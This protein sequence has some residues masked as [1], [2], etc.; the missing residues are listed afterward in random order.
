MG[1]GWYNEADYKNSTGG[2][3]LRRS[4]H[5]AKKVKQI[6]AGFA[7]VGFVGGVAA[8]IYAY[9]QSSSFALAIFVF[10]TVNF[11]LGRGLGDVATDPHKGKRFVYF[12]LQPV[13]LVGIFYATYQWWEIMWLSAVMGF[14]I[15]LVLWQILG[16]MLFPRIHAEEMQDTQER[17]TSGGV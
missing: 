11:Y 14:V 16:F 7:F 9:S 10:L 5:R 6:H 3:P 1:N 15:G 17:M 2:V 4:P 12:T 13:L 8:A